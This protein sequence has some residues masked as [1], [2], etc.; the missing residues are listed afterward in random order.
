MRE[1][2]FEIEYDLSD[3]TALADSIPSTNSNKDFADIGLI[4]SK[5]AF[6]DYMTLEHNY[7]Y[8]DGTMEEFPNAV[9]DIAFF[10]SDMSDENGK[11][12]NNQKITF[13]FTRTHSSFALTLYF[14]GDYPLSAIITWKTRKGTILYK[15]EYEINSN[16]MKI[17]TDK[18]EYGQIEIEFTKAL[19]YRYVKMYFFRFGVILNWDETNVKSASLV[20][21]CDRLSDKLSINKL[22]FDVI[23]VVDNMNMG[24]SE[25][26]HNYFQKTQTMKAYENINGERR[27][28]GKYFLDKFSD[29]TNVGSMS[30]VSYIGLLDNYTFDT[31]TIYN[32][33]LA[34]TVLDAI[35]ETCGITN[36]TI[37]EETSNQLLYGT[38]KPMTCRKA[39]REVLFAC[40]SVIDTTDEENIHIYKTSF[41]I[42]GN[43]TRSMKF[44]TEVEKT[45]YIHSVTIKYAD[46]ELADKSSQVLKGVYPK[47]VNRVTFNAPCKDLSI[48]V[49]KITESGTYYCVFELDSESEVIITGYKYT[50]VN[51]TVTAY[52]DHLEAGEVEKDKSFSCTLCNA[53]TGTELAL[54]ILKYYSYRLEIKAKYLADDN[55]MDGWR[56]FQNSSDGMGDYIAM[57]QKRSIDLS[58]GFIDNTKMIGYFNQMDYLYYSGNE[59]Y[60]GD[61]GII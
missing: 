33:V 56:F 17:Y 46:Y 45:D 4:K 31:G 18:Q 13:G 25:G 15:K 12:S 36:Y 55:G 54:K 59:L 41:S 26:M 58:G 47:G 2:N 30:L 22:S 6:S 19:P 5:T 57:Y 24:N 49:G 23:D 37:D 53:V 16:E 1:T 9:N 38:I 21:E 27:S 43:I 20:Q 44:E 52:R 10:S 3:T 32:G 60:T 11:F 48:N 39:L 35:F 40:H 61:G 28:L 8:L 51:N 7:S 42:N 34:K 29:K 50:S 14:V